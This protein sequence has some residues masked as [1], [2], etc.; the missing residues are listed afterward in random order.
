MN[1]LF[2]RGSESDGE[3]GSWNRWAHFVV[4]EVKRAASGVDRLE[5]EIKE[6]SKEVNGVQNEIIKVA[7][8]PHVEVIHTQIAIIKDD[9][10]EMKKVLEECKK[11]K[12]QARVMFL[13]AS[14]LFSTG[15]TLLGIFLK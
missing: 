15:L 10:F 13:G 12:T 7:A 9:I 5:A 14:F 3:S 11:F 2:N 6:I 4:S 8:S 1:S